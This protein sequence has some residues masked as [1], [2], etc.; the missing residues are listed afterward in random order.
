MS[1]PVVLHLTSLPGGGVDRHIRD[2]ARAAPGRHLVWHTS[3]S[4]DVI[5]DPR[6][7]RFHSLDP[8][9]LEQRPE[10]LAQWLR[11]RGVGMIHAHSVGRAVRRRTEW[12][13]AALSLPF[14]ATLHDVLFLREDGFDS[15]TPL[16]PDDAWLQ[17][18]SAFLGKACARLAPSQYLADVAARY[19][20]GVDVKVVP[21]GSAPRHDP[22]ALPVARPEFL[23]RPPRHVAAV[24]GAIG[25]H[26]GAR[27]LEETVRRL[28]GSDIAIVVIGYLDNAVTPGWRGDH[29][30]VHGTT[31]DD[32]TAP[33]LAAYGASLVFFPNQVPES[34]SYT[35]SDAWA[36]GMPVLAPAEG[37]LGERIERHGGGWL[38]P[39]RFDANLAAAE[40]RRLLSPAA[41]EEVA[42][43]K[44]A[45]DMPDPDRIP[46]LDAMTRSLDALY[47]RFGV[48]A[49][50][51][52]DPESKPAQDLLA[53]TLNGAVFRAELSRLA[54]EM[55][56]VH[57]A[58]EK[59]RGAAAQFA[60]EAREW[61]AKLE[62]DV[63]ALRR[64]VSEE[65]AQREELR[66][67]LD[68]SRAEA[69]RYLRALQQLPQFAQSYLLKKSD[70]GG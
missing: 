39:A 51:A 47:E 14:I 18:T 17:Q 56:Q 38:L 20:Q 26:K 44:S 22:A 28:Q 36:A 48:P 19:L 25:P 34:F 57:A 43:V 65:F 64:Q 60:G 13:V 6:A 30:F 7:Q 67:A 12:A 31:Q 1:A 3:N 70:A 58:L 50:T 42:R 40:L 29:L 62:G 37:A 16:K 21:N 32:E 2:I 59:E 46:P 9:A 8:E 55:A 53:A 54:D 52:P 23:A 27:L 15:A 4:V 66:G 10:L 61:I 69:S 49:G 41:A 63:A 11:S 24:L 68:A 5:E 45:L 35:L 33:L